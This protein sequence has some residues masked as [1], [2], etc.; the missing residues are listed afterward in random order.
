MVGRDAEG[1]PIMTDD[2]NCPFSDVDVSHEKFDPN[3]PCSLCGVLGTLEA[4][5][6]GEI[7]KRCVDGREYR[8]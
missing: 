4:L 7:D 1:T 6:S 8:D 2:K 3:T 5:V